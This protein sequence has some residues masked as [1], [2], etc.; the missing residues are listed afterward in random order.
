MRRLVLCIAAVFAFAVSQP[1]HAFLFK[2][3][4]ETKLVV[5]KCETAEQ[6]YLYASKY[7]KTQVL[8]KEGKKRDDQ[9]NKIIQCYEMVCKTFPND[10]KYTPL[11]YLEIADAI[12]VQ[13]QGK[14]ALKMYQAATDKYP[15]NDYLVARALTSMGKT[16]DNMGKYE[17]G[18]EL[19]KQVVDRFSKSE[20]AST[21][22][23][24][25]RAN[26]YYYTLKE[27][28]PKKK[29]APPEPNQ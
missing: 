14:Q 2:K 29:K 3:K 21:I 28:G 4:N 22:E 5:P 24:V 12:N 8:Y 7:Q 1:A 17:K 26:H 11:A 15:D 18:K 27:D 6:Q 10:T 19:Y 16:Y 23:I 20:S 13:G 9:L 25:K